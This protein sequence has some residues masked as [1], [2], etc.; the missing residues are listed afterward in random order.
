MQ[1]CPGVADVSHAFPIER[2]VTAN[3]SKVTL[4]DHRRHMTHL[5]PDGSDS[6]QVDYCLVH[7]SRGL[8]E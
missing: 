4:S 6:F 7:I 8:G 3:Q 1:M 2:R 5:Y